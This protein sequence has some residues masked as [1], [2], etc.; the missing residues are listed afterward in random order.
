MQV[1]YKMQKVDRFLLTTDTVEHA[2]SLFRRNSPPVVPVI[3]S[4]CIRGL[5]TAEDMAEQTDPAIET[6]AFS[7]RGIMQSDVSCCRAS[8]DWQAICRKYAGHVTGYLLVLDD[9]GH[10]V[11]TVTGQ[12]LMKG[13]KEGPAAWGLENELDEAVDETFPASDP[14]SP[15]GGKL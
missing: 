3:D 10:P 14:I 13:E 8:D 4:W 6:R 12:E 11:G 7:V 9:A 5:V 1:R 15:A 2:A